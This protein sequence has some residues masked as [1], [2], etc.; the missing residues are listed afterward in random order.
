M[1]AE[2]AGREEE[3]D[4]RLVA[5]AAAQLRDRLPAQGRA[6]PRLAGPVDPTFRDLPGGDPAAG[7]A[8]TLVALRSAP[9]LAD[10][11]AASAPAA[12]DLRDQGRRV[13]VPGRGLLRSRE[14]A[15][16]AAQVLQVFSAPALSA[17]LTRAFRDLPVVRQERVPA[18]QIALRFHNFPISAVVRPTD[19]EGRDPAPV[20]GWV[21]RPESIAPAPARP[22]AAWGTSWDSIVRLG[23]AGAIDPAFLVVETDRG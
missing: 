17:A 5:A 23:R 9:R 18:R 8:P 19:R 20:R 12:S 6:P 15:V 2:G 22:P 4:L 21:R 3:V 11:R 16:S 10:R 7:R 14:R 1:V 13:R